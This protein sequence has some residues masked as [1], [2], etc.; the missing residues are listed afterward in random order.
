MY[1]YTVSAILWERF[2]CLPRHG[3]TTVE[4]QYLQSQLGST[5]LSERRRSVTQG[6][7]VK[8]H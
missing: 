1:C 8:L 2:P 5:E 6:G 4:W 3:V 7:L